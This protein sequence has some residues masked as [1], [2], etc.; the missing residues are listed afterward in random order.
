MFNEPLKLTQLFDSSVENGYITGFSDDGIWPGPFQYRLMGFRL[1]PTDLYPR[2]Y[3]VDVGRR[4]KSLGPD[5]CINNRNIVQIQLEYVRC[6][7]D[8]Y[9]KKLKFFV[10]FNGKVYKDFFKLSLSVFS[11]CVVLQEKL[12]RWVRINR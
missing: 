7:F 4:A 6:V 2:P 12:T 8:A 11:C 9:P 3:F 10:S 5:R 1:P